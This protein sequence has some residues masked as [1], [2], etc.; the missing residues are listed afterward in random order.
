ME[1]ARGLFRHPLREQIEALEQ[2]AILSEAKP[3]GAVVDRGYRGI[4]MPGVKIYHPGLQRG[5]ARMLKAMIKRRS[6]IE[7]AIGHIRP[8]ANWAGTGSRIDW[9]CVECC[10]VWRRLQPAHDSEEAAASLRFDSGACCGQRFQ[11]MAFA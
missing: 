11:L 1:D 6:A 7:P 4:V 3:G 9:R 5:I 10:A 2:A 8:M